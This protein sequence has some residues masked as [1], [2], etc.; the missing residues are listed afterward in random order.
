M[1]VHLRHRSEEGAALILTIGLMLVAAV[2]GAAMMLLSQ[3]ETYASYNYKLMTQARYG[4]E[5]GVHKAV[6]YLLNSYAPPA[7]SAIGTTFM[8]TNNPVT[9]NGQPVVL[10]ARSDVTGN[11]P[12][13]SIQT[14]FNTAA[15][16]SVPVGT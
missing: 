9:Y 16:G 14:A 10:S 4:A 15:Q 8:N 7:A 2:I 13:G 3:T 1:S 11:Y 12:T 6:N 5:S